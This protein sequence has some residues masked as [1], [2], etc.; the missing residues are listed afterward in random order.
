MKALIEKKVFLDICLNFLII[1][2]NIK[3]I[4]HA[5]S[6]RLEDLVQIDIVEGSKLWKQKKCVETTKQLLCD[7]IYGCHTKGKLVNPNWDASN[8]PVKLS[9]IKGCGCGTAGRSLASDTR[10]LLFKSQH[11]QYSIS[12]ALICQL[13]VRKD[14]NKEKE[15]GI[16]PLKS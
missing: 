2:N 3:I 1:I 10:D 12:N 5:L 11:R 9:K 16:G 15:A 7:C 8:L 14:E 13:Q 6:K 4:L